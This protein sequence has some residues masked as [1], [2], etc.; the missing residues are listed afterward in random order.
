MTNYLKLRIEKDG[1]FLNVGPQDLPNIFTP[2]G[3]LWIGC[4]G[5]IRV[6]G[7][8]DDGLEFDE[9]YSR[10]T[11]NSYNYPEEAVPRLQ[12]IISG[13]FTP[14]GKPTGASGQLICQYISTGNGPFFDADGVPFSF[15][16][17]LIWNTK[18][19]DINPTKGRE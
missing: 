14:K 4:V 10:T 12:E 2:R 17:Y 16:S 11:G 13:L 5:H 8:V 15:D 1:D 18:Y 19:T 6:N 3:H 7:G 9:I